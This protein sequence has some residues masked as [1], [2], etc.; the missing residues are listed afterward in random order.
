LSLCNYLSEPTFIIIKI[1]NIYFCFD[2]RWEL[3]GGFGKGNLCFENN[4]E[5]FGKFAERVRFIRF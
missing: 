1:I 2:G 3:H 4:F 5:K